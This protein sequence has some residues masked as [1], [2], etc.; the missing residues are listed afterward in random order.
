V[1]PFTGAPIE[2]KADFDE[3]QAMAA[4]YQPVEE[5]GISQSDFNA[6]IQDITKRVRKPTPKSRSTGRRPRL[7][8]P[9]NS[10][11]CGKMT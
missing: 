7:C 3:Y 9:K 2:S 6:L 1:N 4:A 10:S 5:K 11:R 8:R